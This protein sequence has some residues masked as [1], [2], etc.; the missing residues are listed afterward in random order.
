MRDPGARART[1]EARPAR[2]RT[3]RSAVRVVLLLNLGFLLAALGTNLIPQSRIIERVRQAFW[4]GELIE[5]DYLRGDTRRGHH[6]YNDC[7]V[8]QMLTNLDRSTIGR[9]FGPWLHLRESAVESCATLKRLITSENDGH[10][11]YPQRYTRYWHG[12]LPATGVFL[13]IAQLATVRSMLRLGVHAS[14]VLVLLAGFAQRPFLQGET[15]IR[16][17]WAARSSSGYTATCVST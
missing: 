14:V 2:L 13:S 1:R 17:S 15:G 5:R 12:Y 4:E 9:A 3:W 8:L 10:E 7:T 16:G 6:Q 11:L